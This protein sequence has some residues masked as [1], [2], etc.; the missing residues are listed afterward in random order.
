[1]YRLKYF[2]ICIHVLFIFMYMYLREMKYFVL[3]FIYMDI[4]YLH[5]NPCKF[6]SVSSII[7]QKVYYVNFV[8]CL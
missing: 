3:Y 8:C 2:Y 6:S 1:M 4:Q 7:L 5:C